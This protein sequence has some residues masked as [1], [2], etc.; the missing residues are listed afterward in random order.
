MRII[1]GSRKGHTIAAPRGTATRPTG[2]RV[3]EAA[4]N[5][6]GPVDDAAV[7]DLFAGSGAM[8]LEALSRGARR[9][10]FVESDRS[11]CNVIDDNL[12][13]LELTGALVLCADGIRALSR[14]REARRVYD[15]IIADPPYDAWPDLQPRLAEALPPVLA[16]AGVLVV[17]TASRVEPE[18][19]LPVITSRRYG[20]ARI[21]LFTA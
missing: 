9:A 21:T 5:L 3:R 13:R 10:V 4:F 19:P 15:L 17:E 6:I 1:A 8:G 7:L 16:A 11:A 20:S 12:A 2:D 18:L 14:E